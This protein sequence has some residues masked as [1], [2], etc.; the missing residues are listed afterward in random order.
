MSTR[1]QRIAT[2]LYEVLDHQDRTPYQR[3]DRGTRPPPRVG[4]RG[5]CRSIPLACPKGMPDHRPGVKRWILFDTR[6]PAQHG[7]A[8]AT[9]M[10]PQHLPC[11]VTISKII[12][13][14][15]GT[16]EPGKARQSVSNVGSSGPTQGAEVPDIDGFPDA[17]DLWVQIPSAPRLFALNSGNVRARSLGTLWAQISFDLALEVAIRSGS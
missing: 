12:R 9:G 14:R 17:D 3:S 13:H 8:Q 6:A 7:R 11:E 4:R 10:T 5:R 16:R 1:E 15:T 2:R